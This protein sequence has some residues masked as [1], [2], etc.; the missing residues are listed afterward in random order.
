[1]TPDH[2]AT[3]TCGTPGV[4]MA[5][6]AISLGFEGEPACLFNSRRIGLSAVD[7]SMH[8]IR[9]VKGH[10]MLLLLI[11]CYCFSKLKVRESFPQLKVLRI[12]RIKAASELDKDKIII[13]CLS[14]EDKDVAEIARTGKG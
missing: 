3:I 12:L 2:A 11:K 1:M 7:L 8:S 14:E 4:Y 13:I 9:T 10:N 6:K 5:L